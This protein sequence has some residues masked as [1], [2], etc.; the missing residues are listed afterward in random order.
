MAGRGSIYNSQMV[1]QEFKDE[2]NTRLSFRS[3]APPPTHQSTTALSAFKLSSRPFL[4]AMAFKLSSARAL[5]TGEPC[6][7]SVSAD[8]RSESVPEVRTRVRKR[9][10][11]IELVCEED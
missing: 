5:C 6:A 8:R 1:S 11:D 4:A 9:E 3:G 7:I 2:K 10:S